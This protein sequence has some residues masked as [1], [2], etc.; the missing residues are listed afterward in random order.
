LAGE[1]LPAPNPAAIF[2]ESTTFIQNIW[3][4]IEKVYT[5]RGYIQLS[6]IS[7]PV[8]SG[9]CLK[10]H[11]LT[12]CPLSGVQ[13]RILSDLRG[14]GD[15]GGFNMRRAIYL[16]TIFILIYNINLS[17]IDNGDSVP[18][19]LLPFNILENHNLTLDYFSEYFD[20]KLPIN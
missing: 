11:Y 14:Y 16:L 12:I 5:I 7:G 4:F 1:C 8:R 2:D 19:S 10:Y 13:S 9:G 18:A 3:H 6:Q 17:I 15:P 20:P